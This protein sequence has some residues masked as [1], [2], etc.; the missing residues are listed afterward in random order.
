MVLEESQLLWQ[1]NGDL[2]SSDSHK[3]YFFL[4]LCEMTNIINDKTYRPEQ[5]LLFA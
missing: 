5:K 2:I 4:L 1:T 3:I